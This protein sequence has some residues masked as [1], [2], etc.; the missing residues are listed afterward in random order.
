VDEVRA[1]MDA[2]PHLSSKGG[3]IHLRDPADVETHLVG[4]GKARILMAVGC[5]RTSYLPPNFLALTEGHS[6]ELRPSDTG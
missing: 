1:V 2:M 5:I 3:L 4:D 6:S